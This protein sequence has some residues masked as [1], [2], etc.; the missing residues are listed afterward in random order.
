MRENLIQE[1]R[2]RLFLTPRS[3]LLTCL[4]YALSLRDFNGEIIIALESDIHRNKN[5]KKSRSL[6]ATD[7]R[8]ASRIVWENTQTGPSSHRFLLSLIVIN[9]FIAITCST[10][11]ITEHKE[12]RKWMREEKEAFKERERIKTD[13]GSSMSQRLSQGLLR[14]RQEDDVLLLL[15]RPLKII[16]IALIIIVVVTLPVQ[17]LL[18]FFYIKFNELS[19]SCL[20]LSH[21][22]LCLWDT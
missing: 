15:G 22:L 21:D 18:L 19:S 4:V 10:I 8:F 13:Y 14:E 12:E 2:E 11:R 7:F 9:V 3:S 17:S 16:I 1:R 5:E 20:F 6:I